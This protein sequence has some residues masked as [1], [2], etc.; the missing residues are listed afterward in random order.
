M[1]F[2]LNSCEIEEIEEIYDWGILDG[3]T[4][5]PTMIAVHGGDFVK[6]FKTICRAV[7]VKVFAQV[8]SQK[9]NDIV[10]EAGKLHSLGDNVVVKIHCNVEGIKAIS[11]LKATTE[12]PVCATAIHSIIEGLSAARAGADH[13]AVFLG[14]LGEADER[15]TSAVIEGISQAFRV[16]NVSTKIMTAGRS[17]QQ[18]VDGFRVGAHEMTCSYKIWKLFLANSFT[19]ERWAVF[20]SDWRSAFYD[21]NWNSG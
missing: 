4:I 10:E 7:P 15:P 6:N 21:R 5:N 9:R 8:V 13:V 14:L 12:I 16:G 19:R 1:E 2:F 18:V 20:E 11:S 17:L 3:V